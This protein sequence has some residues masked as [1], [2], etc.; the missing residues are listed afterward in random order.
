MRI[1][2]DK[3]RQGRS[4]LKAKRITY[5]SVVRILETLG[6]WNWK[7]WEGNRTAK[8]EPYWDLVITKNRSAINMSS[9]VQ[10]SVRKM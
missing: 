2:K 5:S 1:T 4:F 8:P 7:C 9:S 3:D 6:N 10:E